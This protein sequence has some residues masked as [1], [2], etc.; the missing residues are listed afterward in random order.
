[1]KRRNMEIVAFILVCV[2]IAGLLGKKNGTQERGDNLKSPQNISGRNNSS[3]KNNRPYGPGTQYLKRSELDY[4]DIERLRREAEVYESQEHI[5]L[6]ANTIQELRLYVAEAYGVDPNKI[7][8]LSDGRV[9][10]DDQECGN[11][12]YNVFG[13]LEYYH[14]A[15]L[16][17]YAQTYVQPGDSENEFDD[18]FSDSF[19]AAKSKGKVIRGPW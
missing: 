10:L 12:R 7:D 9:L 1:M 14:P 11:W 17:E 3:S 16:P 15:R 6:T 2:V 4:E 5:E 18:D 19:Q 8:T 13:Q